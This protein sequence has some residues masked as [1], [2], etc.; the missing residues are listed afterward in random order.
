MA[1]D[2]ELAEFLAAVTP[3]WLAERGKGARARAV[4]MFSKEV[5]V[6][7]YVDYYRRVEG[8]EGEAL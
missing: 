7:Q 1:R 2:G 6:G 5:V 8:R 3:E 4:E